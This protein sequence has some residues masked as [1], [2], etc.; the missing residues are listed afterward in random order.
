MIMKKKIC[1]ATPVDY[2]NFGNRLQN[3]AVHVICKRMT[4]EPTTLAVEY[5]YIL[6]F[7]PRYFILRIISFFH[8]SKFYKIYFLLNYN[9][10]NH[11]IDLII[12]IH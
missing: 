3:Y 8:L 9:S 1:I 5:S 11:Y 7:I 2:S 12:H 4:M 10:K 6:G